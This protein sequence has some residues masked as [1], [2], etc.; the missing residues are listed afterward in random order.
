MRTEM[1][2]LLALMMLAAWPLAETRAD[3]PDRWQLGQVIIG[4]SPVRAQGGPWR[5][6]GRLHV[7][8]SRVIESTGGD[9]RLRALVLPRRA[10][11]PQDPPDT[12]RIF[13]DRF[14]ASAQPQRSRG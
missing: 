8:G 14:S 4:Q 5:I 11:E 10:G 1:R 2:A 3:D 9:W 13:H 7:E 12:D 6:D